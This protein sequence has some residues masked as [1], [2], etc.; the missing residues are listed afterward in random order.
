LFHAPVY[1]GR[2]FCRRIFSGRMEK[3]YSEGFAQQWTFCANPVSFA[4]A[5]RTMKQQP[6]IAIALPDSKPWG[7]TRFFNGVNDYADKHK[8]LLTACPVD[9][10]SGDDF[11]LDR[12]RLK[13]WHIDGI[14][15]QANDLKQSELFRKWRIPMVNIGEDLGF[16]CKIPQLAQNNQQVGRFAA[17][18]LI[19]LGLKN[20]AYHGVKGRWYS[21]ERL[22]GFKQAA[23]EA[24]VKVH[25]FLL[26]HMTRDALWNERYEPIKRWLKTLPLPTGLFA[27]HDYRALIV[28]SACREVGLRVPED[29]AVIGSDNDLMVC[30]FSTPTLTSVCVNAYRMGY[31]AA[32]LLDQ[33][34]HGKPS[35]KEPVLIDPTEVVARASTDVIH[36]DDPS[37]KSAIQFL[38][39]NYANAFTMDAVAE[40]A[41][42]SRRSLEMR[43]RTE[44]KTSP[45]LF[46]AGLRLQKAKAMLAVRDRKST[47]EIARACGFGTGKNLRAAF[48]RILN[49]SPTLAAR[50]KFLSGITA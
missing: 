41:H 19:G 13:S 2:F 34:M 11:P 30:E 5:V 8:W 31:E 25:S 26:P 3:P 20:L 4:Q 15:L 45:A 29:V 17:E 33:L 16:D 44:R 27:V 12:S 14:I 48:R 40:A 32:K 6:K 37:V 18:H 39:R 47:E 24:N 22:Q 50:K 46:L 1:P 35:P 36:A 28:L 42:V 21:D 43:F 10:E 49:A 9:P 23:A 7:I 38:Q